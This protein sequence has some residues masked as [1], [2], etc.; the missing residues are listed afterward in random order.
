MTRGAIFVEDKSEI[1]D[2]TSQ[3]AQFI[4]DKAQ[5]Q[6]QLILFQ[7]SEQEDTV[8]IRNVCALSFA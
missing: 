1:S 4:H 3:K 7:E 8:L 2:V 6:S 5:I